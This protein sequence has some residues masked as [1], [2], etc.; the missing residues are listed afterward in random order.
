M[1]THSKPQNLLA[2]ETGISLVLIVIQHAFCFSLYACLH[3]F[4]LSNYITARKT[5]IQSENERNTYPCFFGGL[6]PK[7]EHIHLP[8]FKLLLL[9]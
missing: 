3:F 4:Y 2:C 7:S 1:K 9:L 8:K 5:S 6:S